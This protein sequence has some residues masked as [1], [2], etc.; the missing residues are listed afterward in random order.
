MTDELAT[1]PPQP[2]C[3]FCHLRELELILAEGPS[4]YLLAD[5]APLVGGHL[6][7]VP[8]A[9][10]A[11]YGATPARLDTELLELKDTARR[12]LTEVY[13]A[14]AFFEHG[15]FRQTVY[16]AHLHLLPYGPLT[17]NL[18]STAEASGGVACHGQD[19]LRAWFRQRGHYFYLE[20]PGDPARDIAAQAAIFP[21]EMGVY[22]RSLSAIRASATE[23]EGWSPPQ[24]RYAARGPKLRALAEAWRAWRAQ[25]E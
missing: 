14:P 24:L 17:W 15:V 23:I 16:H 12:F 18:V 19:D 6:L 9:H 4:F 20:S 2:G 5:H 10:Y 3:P 8:R 1:P 21:P 22:G 7:I 11:C 13:R 25:G